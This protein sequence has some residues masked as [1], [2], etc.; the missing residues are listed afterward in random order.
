MKTRF[1]VTHIN[2]HGFRQLSFANQGRNHF[3]TYALARLHILAMI[4]NNS[5]A[6]IADVYGPHPETLDARPVLCYDH[7]D[8]TAIYFDGY[9]PE[10]DLVSTPSEKAAMVRAMRDMQ[11]SERDARAD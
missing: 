11:P 7:G 2:R 1:A 10:Y 4:R 9:A 8:A 6:T 3:D 5:G